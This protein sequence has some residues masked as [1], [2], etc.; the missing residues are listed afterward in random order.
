MNDL[1]QM[2]R[3]NESQTEIMRYMASSFDINK[4]I[5]VIVDAVMDVKHPKLCAVYLVDTISSENKDNIVIRTDYSSMERRLRKDFQKIY[6]DFAQSRKMTDI[7]TGE[8]VKELRF[9]GEANIRS[10]AMLSLNDGDRA[11]GMM[12]VAS[13]EESFFEKGISYF[14]TC[15]IEYNVSVKTTKL[16]LQT[17]DMARKDGLTQ[18]YNRLYFGELFEKATEEAKE[19][20]QA[21]AVALFDIDKF[22]NINDTYGHLAGSMK[23]MQRQMVV[24]HADM[25]ER[26]S[27]LCFRDTMR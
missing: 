18:I 27:C 3:E 7:R 22:K 12:I 15:L 11:Y 26:S 4:N 1:E 20:G 19:K 10:L 14:E 6:T 23:S 8:D 25:A 2:N 21:L 9:I 16:Y 17:Q 24:L 13:D 5:N